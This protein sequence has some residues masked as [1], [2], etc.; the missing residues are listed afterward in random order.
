MKDV[1]ICKCDSVQRITVLAITSYRGL[2]EHV[3]DVL[4]DLPKTWARRFRAIPRWEYR[5]TKLFVKQDRLTAWM[6]TDGSKV[7]FE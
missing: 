3:E 6:R 5:R 1:K 4:E 2:I 7:D